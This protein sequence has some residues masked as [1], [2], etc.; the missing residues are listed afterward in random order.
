M[1][2]EIGPSSWRADDSP[3]G[4]VIK[5][6]QIN[7]LTTGDGCTKIWDRE[8]DTMSSPVICRTNYMGPNMSIAYSE[9]P[10]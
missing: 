6:H 8:P 3:V 2:N 7:S 5:K 9:K 10:E 4:W 1:I